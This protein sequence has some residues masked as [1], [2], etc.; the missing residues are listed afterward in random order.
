M[1]FRV[2]SLITNRYFELLFY[3]DEQLIKYQYKF[4]LR[5]SLHYGTIDTEINI[6]TA[7][8]MYG[9]GLTDARHALNELKK[10]PSHYFVNL[11]NDL[12]HN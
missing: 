10:S 6:Q 4:Q 3:L 7:H 5:Y 12:N 1:N 11:N 9:Q 2:Y 8:N